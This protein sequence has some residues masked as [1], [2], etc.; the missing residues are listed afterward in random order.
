[1]VAMIDLHC[2]TISQIIAKNETL[3]SNNQHFDL[4]RAKK[5]GVCLQV[6]A[7]F[8]S[9]REKDSSLR[10]ILIQIDKFYCELEQNSDHV[11]QVLG[12]DDLQSL[13]QTGKLACLLHLEGAEA[14]GK[15][16]GIFR[17][18]CRMGLRSIGLT[19][20][21]SNQLAGGIAEGKNAAGLTFYG[22][23]VLKE[24]EQAGI[25]LDLS[26]ISEQAFFEALEY[27]NKPVMV[28]HAN[29]R[30]LCNHPRNLSDKQLKLLADNGGVVGL[31]QVSHFVKKEEASLEDFLNH[32]VYIS[33]LIGVKHL[34]L[35]SDFD[36]TDNTVLS[37]VEAYASLEQSLYNRGF[38]RQEV[39]MILQENALRVMRGVLRAL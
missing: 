21:N 36:G 6:F 16:L 28:T 23:K 20:N 4:L 27:Y 33:E 15:D 37:G 30:A 38:D 31:N 17:Q 3:L 19:W 1:M 11:Y 10:E 35:G 24:M 18:L 2:D 14:I 12:G 39:E 22:K 32:M 34:A 13:G 7:L 9:S 25:L 8:S 29:A 5:A 26:H